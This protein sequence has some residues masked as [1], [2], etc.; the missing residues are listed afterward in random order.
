MTKLLLNAVLTFGLLASGPVL[1]APTEALTHETL[2]H[3]GVTYDYTVARTGNVRVI[4]GYDRTNNRRFRLRV[5]HGW[6]DG[7]VDGGTVSFALSEVR[8]IKGLV[9]TASTPAEV[10]A[11]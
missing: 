6:V 8:P 4:D 9:T 7:T 5:A 3:D 2:T 10:A 11:R 1:A